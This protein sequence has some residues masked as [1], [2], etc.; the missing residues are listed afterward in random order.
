[1]L[2]GSWQLYNGE[3]NFDQP[4]EELEACVTRQLLGCKKLQLR[5]RFHFSSVCLFPPP[6]NLAFGILKILELSLN[7]ESSV[8]YEPWYCNT[9]HVWKQHLCNAACWCLSWI[10]SGTRQHKARTCLCARMQKLQHSCAFASWIKASNQACTLSCLCWHFNF[11]YPNLVTSVSPSRKGHFGSAGSL[12][13]P[14]TGSVTAFLPSFL[15]SAP[16]HKGRV[17]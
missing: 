2:Q 6:W 15:Q 16:S 14:S 3:V 17:V 13:L 12:L 10:T 8:L 4:P 5:R 9:Q 11:S 1:M 7:F